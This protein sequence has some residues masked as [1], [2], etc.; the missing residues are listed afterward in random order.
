MK[1]TFR[2][3]TW[4]GVFCTELFLDRTNLQIFLWYRIYRDVD[5]VFDY[6]RM[7]YCRIVLKYVNRKSFFGV[8][9]IT[10]RMS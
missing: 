4:L 9:I 5:R 7:L 10:F 6:Y 3:I 1:F 8:S 2:N